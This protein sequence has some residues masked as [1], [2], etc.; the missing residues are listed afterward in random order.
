LIR[1][2]TDENQLF[3]KEME[4]ISQDDFTEFYDRL[5]NI[6]TYYRQMPTDLAKHFD[7]EE[8]VNEE[9]E[10]H[11]LDRNFTGEEGIARHLDLHS[12]FQEYINIKGMKRIPYLTYLNRFD[13]FKDIDMDVKKTTK[14]FQYLNSLFTYISGWIRRAQPLFNVEKLETDAAV[15]FEEL[16]GK[17]EVPNWTRPDVEL[18]PRLYCVAC[19][20]LFA[21]ESVYEA[22]KKGK[23]HLKATEALA[24]KGSDPLKFDVMAR[25]KEIHE[26]EWLKM[27]PISKVE[28]MIKKYT[29]HLAPVREDTTSHVERKQTL[30]EDERLED[31]EDERPVDLEESDDDEA[32][33]KLYNP[34]KLPI[35]WD[36]KPIPFWLYKLHGLGVEYPCEICGG[37]VYMGRKAFERHFQEFRHA[38]GMRALGIPN[39][40]QFRDITKIEDAYR[41]IHD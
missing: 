36:G 31:Q 14:Y 20:K 32:D 34:L 21:N 27:K 12:I 18:D 37:Y 15:E 22:H 25:L 10:E 33:G 6:K 39:S 3:K 8:L 38:H 28:F 11:D 7:P 24:K 5:Q 29:S 9:L 19:D 26:E 16:W 30:T 17:D 1:L 35:G 40:A 13:R 2:Y 4:M 41:C 23:K